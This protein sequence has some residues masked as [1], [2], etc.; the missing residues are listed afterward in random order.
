MGKPI[1]RVSTLMGFISP[2][3][4][5]LSI[6]ALDLNFHLHFPEHFITAKQNLEPFTDLNDFPKLPQIASTTRRYISCFPPRYFD[7]ICDPQRTAIKVVLL[8]SMTGY[9]IFSTVSSTLLH[10]ARPR[11]T[12]TKKKS[13]KL[14]QPLSPFPTP[15]RI[16]VFY[17]VPWNTRS[18][19]R[20]VAVPRSRSTKLGLCLH[21]QMI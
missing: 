4:A 20:Q 19:V 13:G 9:P 3:T 10:T 6:R 18:V 8:F 17:L 7:P 5:C 15:S 21:A 2:T 14:F 1:Q 16:R 11:K 12:E